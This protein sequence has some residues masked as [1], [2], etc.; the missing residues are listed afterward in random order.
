MNRKSSWDW[1]L[2]VDRL[3]GH[4]RGG[5][6]LWDN[7]NRKSLSK[8]RR[9]S[10]V[11]RS[12]AKFILS[13]QNWRKDSNRSPLWW[14]FIDETTRN[15]RKRLEKLIVSYWFC[16]RFSPCSNKHWRVY[17]CPNGDLERVASRK[18]WPCGHVQLYLQVHGKEGG[19]VMNCLRLLKKEGGARGLWRGNGINVIKIAPESALKFVT[20]DSLKN[21]IRVS[22]KCIRVKHS[23]VD[24][25][26]KRYSRQRSI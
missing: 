19:T 21:I 1:S 12:S 10:V 5:T 11:Q 3:R 26:Q 7:R 24:H 13:Y 25:W 17:L 23:L 9:L 4:W 8:W 14:C 6:R 16:G 22:M 15:F 20:Y 18:V 2:S